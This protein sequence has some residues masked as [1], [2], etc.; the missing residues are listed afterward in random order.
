MVRSAPPANLPPECN[1]SALRKAS[2]RTSQLFDAVLAPTDLKVTQYSILRVI[3]RLGG[4]SLKELATELVMDRSTVGHNLRPLE[5]DG[6]LALTVDPEDRRS[7]KVVL[8]RAGQARFAEATALWA[9]AQAAFETAYGTE[10]AAALRDA[11]REL[12]SEAF[13]DQFKAGLSGSRTRGARRE[14]EA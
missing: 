9:R 8:T 5:R 7:R 2:R 12:T 11:L 6:L 13:A 3:D 1:N 10:R 4:A 14:R